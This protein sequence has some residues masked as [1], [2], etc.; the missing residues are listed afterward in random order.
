MNI[1]ASALLPF[2]LI[3]DYLQLNLFVR[4]RGN[5]KS[6]VKA[7]V[8]QQHFWKNMTT[9]NACEIFQFSPQ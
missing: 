1:I 9:P 3:A 4:I 7:E 2:P 5:T 8:S 6:E